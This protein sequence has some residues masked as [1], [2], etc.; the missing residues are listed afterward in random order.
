MIEYHSGLPQSPCCSYV[1]AVLQ[2]IAD[3]IA[4]AL[5]PDT[6]VWVTMQ[7]EMGVKSLKGLPGSWTARPHGVPAGSGDDAVMPDCNAVNT[8]E[9][10]AAQ[11]KHAPASPPALAGHGVLPS[12][13]VAA[14]GCRPAQPHLR[15]QGKRVGCL[16]A[17]PAVYF[18]V[19]STDC[20]MQ[21]SSRSGSPACLLLACATHL[22]QHTCWSRNQQCQALR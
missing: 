8:V 17:C 19:A 7:G 13:R 11:V 21:S 4:G 6:Q 2:P 9:A 3:A 10:C 12:Q 16:P 15:R 22:Q 14:G 20:P 5:R 18:P 1:E